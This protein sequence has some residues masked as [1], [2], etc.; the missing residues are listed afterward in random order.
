[1]IILTIGKRSEIFPV[2]VIRE[3]RGSHITMGLAQKRSIL[4]QD[5]LSFALLENV[6][7]AR[8]NYPIAK[9]YNM[10][11]GIATGLPQ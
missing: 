3:S 6:L 8:G 5:D 11:N 7:I 2:K 1:M 10:R 9:L 4:L